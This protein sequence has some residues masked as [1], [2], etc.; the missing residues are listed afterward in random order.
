MTVVSLVFLSVFTSSILLAAEQV[1]ADI[2]YAFIEKKD[3]KK[4]TKTKHKFFKLNGYQLR[5]TNTV[6][7][8]DKLRSICQIQFYILYI[9][10]VF[11]YQR[12]I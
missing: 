5:G 12:I 1:S 3:N 11:Q 4:A 7:T 10:V 8:V 2:Y 6:L 9:Y